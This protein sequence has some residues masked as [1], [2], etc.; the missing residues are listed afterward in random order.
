MNHDDRRLCPAPTTLGQIIGDSQND[1]LERNRFAVYALASCLLVPNAAK[2]FQQ[3]LN[4]ERTRKRQHDQFVKREN[5]RR[6]RELRQRDS[7]QRT[8]DRVLELT[9]AAVFP[10]RPEATV[11]NIDG[12]RPPFN[13]PHWTGDWTG[14]YPPEQYVVVPLPGSNVLAVEHAAYLVRELGYDANAAWTS[15]VRRPPQKSDRGKV[16][17]VGFEGEHEDGLRLV[18]RRRSNI[19]QPIP[20][21]S[22]PV[23]RTEVGGFTKDTVLRAMAKSKSSPPMRMAAFEVVFYR[24]SPTQT[25][26]KYDVGLEALKKASTRLRRNIQSELGAQ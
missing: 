25:A 24:Q 12:S 26:E 9:D 13:P 16:G 18:T 14:D 8:L 17:E 20:I 5:R 7:S 23:R 21:V 19:P 3:T 10:D 22:A 4:K 6:A 11:R 2:L 1:V 15:I